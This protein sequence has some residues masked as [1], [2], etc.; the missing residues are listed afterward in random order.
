MLIFF[1][2]IFVNI[3]PTAFFFFPCPLVMFFFIHV[4]D[5]V[6]QLIMFTIDLSL[7]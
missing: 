5:P 3:F 7:T 1:S 6:N 2:K 4:S